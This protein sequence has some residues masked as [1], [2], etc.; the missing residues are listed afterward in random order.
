M[1]GQPETVEAEKLSGEMVNGVS[2]GGGVGGQ[3]VG[4]TSENDGG[5]RDKEVK[6]F[7]EEK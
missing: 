1:K 3:E 4:G 6:G 5:S 7:G 2:P